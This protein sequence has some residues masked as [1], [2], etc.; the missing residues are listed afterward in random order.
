[1]DKVFEALASDILSLPT[2]VVVVLI[3]ATLVFY[4]FKESISTWFKKEIKQSQKIKKLEHHRFFNV[5]DS[6]EARIKNMSFTT[7]GDIDI[8]KTKMMHELIT[9]KN[10]AMQ[11]HINGLVHSRGIDEWGVYELQFEFKKCLGEL[12]KDYNEKALKS[13]VRKGVSN[14][15]ADYLIQNYEDYRSIMV[16]AFTDSID[17]VLMNS[18]YHSNF[19][20]V[21][22]LLEICCVAIAVIPRD[23]RSSFEAVNGRYIKYKHLFDE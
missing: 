7:D 8:P 1:M 12:V 17:S 3:F 4:F 15:D 2:A 23:V 20:K 19:D 16:E 21:N 22:T 5:C 13:F 18:D 14:S 6:V 11:K 9:L 10:E